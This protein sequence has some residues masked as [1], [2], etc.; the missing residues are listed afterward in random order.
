[1]GGSGSKNKKTYIYLDLEKFK[2]QRSIN[3]K[4]P[5]YRKSTLQIMKKDYLE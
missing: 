2:G 1:M 3:Y 4:Y 5:T